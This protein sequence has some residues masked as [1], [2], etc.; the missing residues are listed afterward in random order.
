MTTQPLS[1]LLVAWNKKWTNTFAVGYKE[2]KYYKVHGSV[3]E[4]HAARF[5]EN[6]FFHLLSRNS[7][8]SGHYDTYIKCMEWNAEIPELIALGLS[9][10]RCVLHHSKKVCSS[11]YFVV[12]PYAC[13]SKV[14]SRN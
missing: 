14:P 11:F 13:C 10:G 4:D 12:I 7:D 9:D 3:L 2:I 1:N 5:D 6:E 8:F